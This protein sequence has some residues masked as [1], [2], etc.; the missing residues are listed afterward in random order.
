MAMLPSLDQVSALIRHRRSIK[1]AGMDPAKAIDRAVLMTLLENATWAPSHGLTEPWR[2]RVYEGAAREGLADNLQRIY[3][4]VTP[5]AEVRED[6]FAKLRDNVLQAPVVI[7]C[8]M[9]RG[10]VDKIPELEEIEAVAC[11]LQNLM[12]SASAIGL[13]SFWSSPPLLDSEAFKNWL[14]LGAKDRCVGLMYVGW[15]KDGSAWPT[16]VRKPVAE[17]VSWA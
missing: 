12:L 10:G 8:L 14:G 1:P 7:V 4:D 13:G 6:K 3:R 15:A 5:A 2:F 11:A 9:Q 17:C 16:S